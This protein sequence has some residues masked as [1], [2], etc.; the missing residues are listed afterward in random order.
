M[1]IH[2]PSPEIFNLFDRLLLMVE[3]RLV[4]QGAATKAVPYFD[5][6]FGLKC[7]EFMNPAEFV[8]QIL[9][10]ED[11]TNVQRYPQYFESYNSERLPHILEEISSVKVSALEAREAKVSYLSTFA[12]LLKRDITN[13]AR[14]PLLVKSRVFQVL[15]LSVYYGGLYFNAGRKDYT[16]YDN[17]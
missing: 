7:P 2:Q 1:T 12:A 10:P 16:N 17:W 11:K 6:H 13:I 15:F 3:G 5:S 4:Y 8:I 9:H 14:N